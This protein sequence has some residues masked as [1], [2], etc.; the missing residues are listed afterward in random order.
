MSMATSKNLEKSHAWD[1]SRR[2][3]KIAIS[4]SLHFQALERSKMAGHP[5]PARAP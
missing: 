1:F 5:C 3:A 4:A 2:E